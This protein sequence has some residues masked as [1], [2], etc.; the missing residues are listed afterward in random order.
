MTLNTLL[1]RM[2]SITDALEEIIE[3]S[4]PSR[5]LSKS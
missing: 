1:K 4:R 3:P 5:S 2:D